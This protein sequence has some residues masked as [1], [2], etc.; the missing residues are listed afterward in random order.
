MAMALATTALFF[1]RNIKAPARRH[2]NR[3][4]LVIQFVENIVACRGVD[5]WARARSPG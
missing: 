4:S 1:E 3:A 5:V 2:L